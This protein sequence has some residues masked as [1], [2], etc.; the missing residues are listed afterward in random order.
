MVHVEEGMDEY[1]NRWREVLTRDI[2][3]IIDAL[4]A[5]ALNIVLNTR[6]YL[7]KRFIYHGRQDSDG[8]AVSE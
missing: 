1:H 5:P 2:E 6:I 8:A 4:P 7:H 3:R